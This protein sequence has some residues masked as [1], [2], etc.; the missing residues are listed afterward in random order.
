MRHGSQ[1]E[2]VAEHVTLPSGE[3][4]ENYLTLHAGA[5]VKYKGD[6]PARV[7]V[8]GSA[9]TYDAKGRPSFYLAVKTY[10]DATRLS[11]PD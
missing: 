1:V 10:T 4:P 3:R 7:V 2:T 11:R 8:V 6:A 5:L 9:D